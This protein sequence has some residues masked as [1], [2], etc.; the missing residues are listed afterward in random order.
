MSFK[1]LLK[2]LFQI[3]FFC[4]FLLIIGMIYY[5]YH[6]GYIQNQS[7]NITQFFHQTMKK[8]GF[9][10][11]NVLITGRIRTPSSD[12]ANALHLTK[13]M[14]MTQVDLRQAFNKL[15]QLPWIKTVQ[16]HRQLPNLIHLRIV[17]KTPIALWQKN[18]KYHPIDSE[19][20]LIAT[21]FKGL[22]YLVILVGDNAP[23][24]APELVN[25]ISKY[26]ELA[27]RTMSAI[28]IGN[29]RWNLILDNVQNG[30]TIELPEEGLAYALQRLDV[31]HQKHQILNRQLSL[32]DLRLPNKL[33]V[34][35]PDGKPIESFKNQSLK[36]DGDHV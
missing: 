14:P 31:L 3:F 13:E 6:V 32:I 22:E 30:L 4:I 9:Y 18:G 19:G 7:K 33:I 16:I 35:T 24:Y 17:E 5:A 27:R 20:H 25:E 36:G 2:Y 1:T 11:N 28:R 8:S 26:P 21:S 12:I 15:S 29:R 10:V 34:Q 23:E